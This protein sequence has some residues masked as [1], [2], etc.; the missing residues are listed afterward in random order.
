MCDASEHEPSK[1]DVRHSFGD[2]EP[3]FIVADQM[4]HRVIQPKVRSACGGPLSPDNSRFSLVTGSPSLKELTNKLSPSVTSPF[5]CVA[6][7]VA[8]SCG[9]SV[10]CREKTTDSQLSVEAA[11]KG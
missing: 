3:R 5:Q 7:A 8:R 11:Q 1:S 9:F 6:V 4:R 2:I 10:S